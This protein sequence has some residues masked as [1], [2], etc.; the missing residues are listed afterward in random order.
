MLAQYLLIFAIGILFGA[1]LG[2]WMIFRIV[3][4][5]HG[6]IQMLIYEENHKLWYTITGGEDE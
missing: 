4:M 1:W 2:A 6:R 3:E 5:M